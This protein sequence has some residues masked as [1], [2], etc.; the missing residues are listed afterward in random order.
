MKD[1]TRPTE[2]ADLVEETASSETSE[3]QS[4]AAVHESV[5]GG[6]TVKDLEMMPRMEELQKLEEIPVGGTTNIEPDVIGAIA[7]IAAEGIE[8]VAS[9]GST[10]LRRALSERLGGA[11]RRARGVEVELGTREAILDINLKVIYGFNI[12]EMVTKVRLAVAQDLLQYAGLLAKEVNIKIVGIE[13][14]ARMPGRVQ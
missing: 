6:L 1:K 12:P 14:P 3:A 11:E 7:G 5:M 2:E 13:F 8:G 9:L 10:S 4:T